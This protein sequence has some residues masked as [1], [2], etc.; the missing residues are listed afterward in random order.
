MSERNPLIKVSIF[1]WVAVLFVIFGAILIFGRELSD[2][3]RKCVVTASFIAF[4]IAAFCMLRDGIAYF[5]SLASA[6][7]IMIFFVV[8]SGVK[9]KAIGIAYIVLLSL[10]YFGILYIFLKEGKRG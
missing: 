9:M 1:T 5:I 8:S 10:V 2:P 7:P 4:A 3:W 6:S